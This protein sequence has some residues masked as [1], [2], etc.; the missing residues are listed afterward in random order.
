MEITLTYQPDKGI[1]IGDILLMWD[2]KREL[3]RKLL[4]NSFDV[5]DKIVDL[6]LNHQGDSSQNINQRRDIYKNFQGQENY[7][8]LNY[9][10]NDQLSEV[11]IH[12]GFVIKI[13]EQV[14]KFSMDI[15]K[16]AELLTNISNDKCKFSDGE[17]FFEKLK[18][19]VSSSK[20]MGGD[21]NSIS[22]F[23]GS[24]DV[25]HLIDY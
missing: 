20:A 21:S 6:S 16:V 10:I 22:Y 25:T 13:K 7:F 11:E 1:I 23:Y 4:N 15:E 24:K 18:L 12:H 9:D 19:T 3:A 14:I 8:F 17:Y 5:D 2:T